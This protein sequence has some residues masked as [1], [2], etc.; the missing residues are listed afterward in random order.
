VL[1]SG[2]PDAAKGGSKG[3]GKGKKGGS[4]GKGKPGRYPRIYLQDLEIQD[5]RF[6]WTATGGYKLCVDQHGKMCPFSLG[7]KWRQGSRVVLRSDSYVVTS[8]QKAGMPFWKGE[9]MDMCKHAVCAH[10]I[11][12]LQVKKPIIRPDFDLAHALITDDT[13]KVGSLYYVMDGQ[14]K[15]WVVDI[16]IHWEG[17]PGELQK[18]STPLQGV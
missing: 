17:I 16:W 3:K 2:H 14:Q 5:G 15:K 18:V 10:I 6:S 9:G 4:K 7:R 11:R 13:M 8:F 1:T 12:E